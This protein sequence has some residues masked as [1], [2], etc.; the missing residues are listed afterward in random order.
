MNCPELSHSDLEFLRGNLRKPV[1]LIGMMGVGKTHIGRKLASRLGFEFLDSDK[2]IEE[3]ADATVSE[4]FEE[5]GEEKFRLCEHNSILDVLNGKPCV[6][7]TGGG[8]VINEDT[9][10]AIREKSISVWLKVEIS[11]ILKRLESTDDR[12]L[13]KKGDPE[14]ILRDL[15]NKREA[16][17]AEADIHIES[18]EGAADKTLSCLINLLCEKLKKDRV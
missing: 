16:F 14:Q 12:P 4:I 7:A 5:Y 18:P 11:D 3:K 10:R 2:I 17:Y 8:A 1:V 6:L 15:M 13:L 9:R